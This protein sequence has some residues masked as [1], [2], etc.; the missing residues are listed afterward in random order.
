MA[1]KTFKA[2]RYRPDLSTYR[3]RQHPAPTCAHAHPVKVAKIKKILPKLDVPAGPPA[4][5]GWQTSSCRTSTR[6]STPRCTCGTNKA[7]S[8]SGIQR[9]HRSA[10]WDDQRRPQ[11][12]RCVPRRECGRGGWVGV[13]GLRG[14]NACPQNK[15]ER[16]AGHR[17]LGPA[18]SGSSTDHPSRLQ[19]KSSRKLAPYRPNFKRKQEKAAPHTCVYLCRSSS[20]WP[21]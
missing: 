17:T 6:C 3:R 15:E 7:A 21:N 10:R 18:R 19:T 4:P 12:T 5:P 20:T 14:G 16:R 9:A 13:G 8:V 11:S 2:A 1:I